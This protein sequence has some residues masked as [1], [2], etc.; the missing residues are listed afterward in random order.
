MKF[1]N[2]IKIS[3]I[4]KMG[5]SKVNSNLAFG[6]IICRRNRCKKKFRNI[7]G[8]SAVFDSLIRKENFLPT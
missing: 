6:T 5:K 8:L 3:G 1:P 7:C 4:M 2:W